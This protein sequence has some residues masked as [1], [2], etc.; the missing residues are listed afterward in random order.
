MFYHEFD[1]WEEVEFFSSK[2]KKNG[3]EFLD[4]DLQT[5]WNKRSIIT[6]QQAR[7]NWFVHFAEIFVDLHKNWYPKIGQKCTFQEKIENHQ[8][9]LPELAKETLNILNY[10]T[11]LIEDKIRSNQISKFPLF[12]FS[13]IIDNLTNQQIVQQFRSKIPTNPLD[14][15]S[16][17]KFEIQILM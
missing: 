4:Q 11:S 15:K 12:F 10:S 6:D 9:F 13:F 5:A 7:V 2:E 14:N 17:S 16:N 8:A 3:F 1:K